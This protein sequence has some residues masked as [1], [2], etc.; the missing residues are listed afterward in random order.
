M[1]ILMLAAVGALLGLASPAFA[2]ADAALAAEVAEAIPGLRVDLPKQVD[3][4]TTWTGIRAEGTRFV[5]EM[6]LST[7][8]EPTQLAAT[9][10]AAQRLN[11]DRLCAQQTITTFIRRGGSMRHIYTDPAGQSFET[12]V[13]ACP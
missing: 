6:R 8:V 4:I 10:A 11:Q 3:E 13:T 7:T 1:R 2:Q 9:R 12:L 5:Y